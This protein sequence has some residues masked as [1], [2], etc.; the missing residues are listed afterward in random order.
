MWESFAGAAAARQGILPV[1]VPPL[2][3]AAAARASQWKSF[4]VTAS[5]AGGQQLSSVRGG[6]CSL[7]AP[8]PPPQRLLSPSGVLLQVHLED[9]LTTWGGFPPRPET[10]G[11]VTTPASR[12][13]KQSQGESEGKARRSLHYLSSALPRRA[14]ASVAPPGSARS[15]P[16]LNS[17]FPGPPARP[18]QAA[19]AWAPARPPHRHPAR[20]RT[21]TPRPAALGAVMAARSSSS[22]HRGSP[23]RRGPAIC[24]SS[25]LGHL[26]ST[27]RGVASA[28]S[29]CF[30][31]G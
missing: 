14:P 23:A 26:S 6:D 15:A 13:P 11:S 1:A 31:K 7:E 25:I 16:L 5:T 22:R 19:S 29:S 12:S 30:C 21:R 28:C 2:R 18:L 17:G 9:T 10:C 27:S 8:A 4:P 24:G 20:S 3:A